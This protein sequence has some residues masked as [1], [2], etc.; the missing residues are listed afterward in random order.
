MGH[1]AAMSGCFK[2][3]ATRI[4]KVAT[5]YH[6]VPIGLYESKRVFMHGGGTY[7]IIAAWL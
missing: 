2:S 1:V 3:V 5:N 6:I 7:S 4:R